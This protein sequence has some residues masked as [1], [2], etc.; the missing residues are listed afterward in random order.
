LSNWQK[1]LEELRG[2]ISKNPSIHIDRYIMVIPDDVRAEFYRFFDAIRSEYVAEKM[3]GLL[4]EAAE[5]KARYAEARDAL[6][7]RLNLVSVETS[8]QLRWFLNDPQ[9][10]LMHFL[11][12]TLFELIKNTLSPEE[13][14]EIAAH[15]IERTARELLHR[16][17]RHWVILSLARLMSPDQAF[18]VP[19]PDQMIEPE[20]TDA[21]TIP[22]INVHE[23][24]GIEQAKTV[25]MDISQYTPFTSPNLVVHSTSLNAFAGLREGYS[26]TF[27]RAK[28]LSK[29]VE[30]LKMGQI[31]N[32]FGT[33]DLWP[34]VGIYLGSTKERL[35]I[36]ADYYLAA[37]PA[38]IADVV[39]VETSEEEAL[40][41]A[42]R[43]NEVLKPITG[44]YIICRAPL[45]AGQAETASYP[46]AEQSST[47]KANSVLED[48]VRVLVVGYDASKLEPMVEALKTVELA[49]PAPEDE[50]LE[51]IEHY[52]L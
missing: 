35:K 52:K 24:P 46:E 45:I 34:D 37:R 47:A 22:G 31:R 49:P 21:E 26:N 10:G 16:G 27:R 17:Y 7:T 11:A 51:E 40:K 12:D 39:A 23:M 14:D 33:A 1:R 25:H 15:T 32:E 2:Y 6:M 44:S 18:T 42:R 30:W 20:L 43:H 48:D 8:P 38:A 19:L 9:E 41:T 28:A 5:L 13:F 50:D 4:A 29:R 36:L 3:P